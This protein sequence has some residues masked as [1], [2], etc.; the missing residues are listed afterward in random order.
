MMVRWILNVFLILFWVSF[1]IL[2]VNALV[3][4]S[5]TVVNEM[6]P[7]ETSQ[8][9]ILL[10]NDGEEDIEEVSVSLDLTDVPFAPYE[11]S[12]EHSIDEIREGK[13][14][15]V[16]FNVVALSNSKS[17]IYKIP[18]EIKYKDLIDMELKTKNSLISVIISSKPLIDV[19]SEGW[20]LMGK[21]NEIS[22]K[23]INKGLSD[24]KFLEIGFSGDKYV[25][26]LE[27]KSKYIGDLD[28][29]DFDI[30]D[31]KVYLE[32]KD[33]SNFILP[34]NV[35]YRDS[36]NKEYSEVHNVRLNVYTSSRAIELGLLETDNSLKY[37]SGGGIFII[38]FFIYRW[39][40]KRARLNNSKNNRSMFINL[41]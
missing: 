29:D 4:D 41:K 30:I 14:K 6:A 25:N 35:Y 26:V 12:S 10:D 31:L 7:G 40:R 1:M 27:S 21:E 38:L 15:N 28:S 22:I 11:S 13:S 19:K 18:I 9:R 23:I 32:A 24:A 2:G 5:V 34:V 8:I 3:I 33:N 17:G 37:I 36:L 16:E 20:Y 39:F